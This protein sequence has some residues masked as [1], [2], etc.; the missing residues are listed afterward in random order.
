MI[1]IVSLINQTM[2][3]TNILNYSKMIKR[4]LLI[5]IYINLVKTINV[6]T[7]A[8]INV[9]LRT[10]MTLIHR[11]GHVVLLQQMSMKHLYTE[12]IKNKIK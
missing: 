8:F 3:T 2:G 6:C 1:K 9:H 11:C 7:S 12:K 5:L 10:K 4:H